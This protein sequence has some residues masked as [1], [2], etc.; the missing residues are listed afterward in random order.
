MFLMLRQLRNYYG[1][2]QAW[3]GAEIRRV[4]EKAAAALEAA[5]AQQMQ[6]A[7]FEAAATMWSSAILVRESLHAEDTGPRWHR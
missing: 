2:T 4:E 7:D 3:T 5:A 1:S 6:E